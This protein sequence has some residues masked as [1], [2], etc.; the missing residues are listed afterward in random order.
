MPIQPQNLDSD[1][2]QATDWWGLGIMLFEMLTG[3]APFQ[4]P[5]LHVG[6][7]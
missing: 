2:D 4:A 7:H 1:P 6:M 3:D 5:M